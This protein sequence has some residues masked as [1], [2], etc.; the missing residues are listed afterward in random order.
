MQ[1][2]THLRHQSFRR[3]LSTVVN[4][5]LPTESSEHQ[6][7]IQSQFSQQ[8]EG[9]Y[10]FQAHNQLRSLS[11]F[12][13]FGKY[14]KGDCVVD[15]GCGPGL[16][17]QYIS[18]FVKEAIGLDLT[19]EMIRVAQEGI[20]GADKGKRF[21]NISFVVGNMS[22][23][24]FADASVDGC[25]TRYT[26]HHLERPEIAFSEMVRITKQG[27][28][29]VILDATP[30][31]IKA[32]AYNAFEKLRDPSHTRALTPDE[33]INI[34][35]HH[36]SEHLLSSPSF[37]QFSLTVDPEELMDKSFPT[38]VSRKHL[39]EMLEKDIPANLLGFNCQREASSGK[40]VASFPLTAVV[41][42]KL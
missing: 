6:N 36:I 11:I 34:G 16:V 25:I 12:Q 3:F 9:F 1:H 14:D 24:H 39:V 35:S 7:L 23:V 27:G 21:R 31:P 33:L 8:A 10:K 42:N 15:V 13:E 30:H 4:N 17:T 37:E 32:L 5:P 18:Q 40:L 19:P 22:Q 26:F 2:A 41:W 38:E 29:I 20:N 28:R